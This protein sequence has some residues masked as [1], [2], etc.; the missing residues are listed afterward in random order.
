VKADA[1]IGDTRAVLF[2]VGA[3]QQLAI[4]FF[5]EGKAGKGLQNAQG[6]CPIEAANIGAG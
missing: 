5:G 1:V 2:R 6:V 3:L 4:A